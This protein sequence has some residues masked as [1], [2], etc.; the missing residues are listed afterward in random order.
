MKNGQKMR[1]YTREKH[2]ENKFQNNTA[3]QL[4]TTDE[5][6]RPDRC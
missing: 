1:I 4:F 5:D 3:K 6:S 2:K